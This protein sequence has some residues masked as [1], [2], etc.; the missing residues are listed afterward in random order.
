VSK[1]IFAVTSCRQRQQ[2]AYVLGCGIWYERF[3][4]RFYARVV[5]A[6][7]EAPVS[8]ELR[9]AIA[10]NAVVALCAESEWRGKLQANGGPWV[11]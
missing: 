8:A 3:P 2:H 5:E 11:L 6:M 7:G 10:I 4:V 9:L 1:K